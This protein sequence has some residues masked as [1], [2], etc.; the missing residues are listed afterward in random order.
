MLATAAREARRGAALPR[1]EVR[2]AA[3]DRP[4]T[5]LKTLDSEFKKESDETDA[6]VRAIEA[7]RQPEPKIQALWDRGEPSPTYIYRRGDPQNPGRLVGPG[8]PRC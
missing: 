7:K 6:R 2:E 5:T 4:R 3:A 1:R 8:V